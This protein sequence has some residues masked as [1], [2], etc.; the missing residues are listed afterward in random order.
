MPSR[1]VLRNWNLSTTVDTGGGF[2]GDYVWFWGDMS[3]YDSG[4][5]IWYDRS[6]NGNNAIVSGSALARTGSLGFVFNGTNN[7]LRWN[8]GGF[9][10]SSCVDSSFTIQVTLQPDTSV[11]NSPYNT[12][13][14][15]ANQSGSVG[16][17]GLMNMYL[18]DGLS[19]PTNQT[20]G[21]SFNPVA[22]N[23][24][25]YLY[26]NQYL[27]SVQTLTWRFYPGTT[28][29]ELP[30]EMEYFIE[31]NGA[32]PYTNAGNIDFVNGRT[33]TVSFGIPTYTTTGGSPNLTYNFYKGI[34][35]DIV[36]YK[37]KLTN[38]EIYRNMYV[39]DV[40]NAQNNR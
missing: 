5:A 11:V 37:K 1:N 19:G 35:R 2:P 10:T 3:S 29:S 7:S 24:G 22:A 33:P 8:T 39:L 32:T 13:A 34:V 17:T 16:G 23:R 36:I 30:M 40:I 27:N 4:S 18:N 14:L 21:F 26:G 12:T 6:G 31:Y 25:F 9:T 38:Y 15:F 28:G 20:Q